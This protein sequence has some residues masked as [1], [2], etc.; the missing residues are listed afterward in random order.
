[1]G[2]LSEEFFYIYFD[3]F[4]DLIIWPSCPEKSVSPS[5]HVC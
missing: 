4:V 3:D 2:I 1:M 5:L